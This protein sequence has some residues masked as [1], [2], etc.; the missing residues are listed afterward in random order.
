MDELI[1]LRDLFIARR[2][3][4]TLAGASIGILFLGRKHRIM[5]ELEKLPEE[6]TIVCL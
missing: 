2:I 3:R 5:P 4:E 6:Y 1:H